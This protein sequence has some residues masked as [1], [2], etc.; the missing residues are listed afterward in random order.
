MHLKVKVYPMRILRI[1]LVSFLITSQTRADYF[2]PKVF[3]GG[4][5]SVKCQDVTLTD[6]HEDF[7]AGFLLHRQ[8]AEKANTAMLDVKSLEESLAQCSDK[9]KN[10]PSNPEI[11]IEMNTKTKILMASVIFIAGVVAGVVISK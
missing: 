8:D 4:T 6:C 3:P 2:K 1:A 7:P 10:C 5:V 9:V 11:N